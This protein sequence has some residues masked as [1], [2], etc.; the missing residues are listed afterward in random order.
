MFAHILA[1]A[2]EVTVFSR[3]VKHDRYKEKKFGIDETWDKD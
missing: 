3:R 1:C 2:A